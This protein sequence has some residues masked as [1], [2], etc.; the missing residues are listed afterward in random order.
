MCILLWHF[1]PAPTSWPIT[2]ISLIVSVVP[3]HL[4]LVDFI[5]PISRLLFYA[6]PEDPSLH[7]FVPHFTRIAFNEYAGGSV[8]LESLARVVVGVGFYEMELDACG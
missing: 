3:L 2:T 6:S 1:L 7:F 8:F 5:P 4:I